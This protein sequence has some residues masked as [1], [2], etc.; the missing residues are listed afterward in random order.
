MERKFKLLMTILIVICIFC[1][2]CK[3]NSSVSKENVP[4]YT[5]QNKIDEFDELIYVDSEYRDYFWFNGKNPYIYSYDDWLEDEQTSCVNICF[6][7]NLKVHKE[8]NE[9]VIAILD[10]GVNVNCLDKDNIWT[11]IKEIPN[12]NIDDD[13][14]GYIDDINGYNFVDKNNCLNTSSSGYHGNYISSICIG[15]ND[16]LNY[17]GLLNETDVKVMFLKV[18]DGENSSGS[19]ANICHAIE[20]AEENGADICNLSFCY[21]RNDEKIKNII[22]KSSMTFI[23]AA[24][25]NGFEIESSDRVYPAM[26]NNENVICVGNMRSDG[27][28]SYTSNYSNNYVDIVAP[29]TDIIGMYDEEKLICKSG[30]SQA[31]IIFT[32]ELAF[33]MEL[34]GKKHISQSE[35]SSFVKVT[36]ELK[37]KCTLGGYV[38]FSYIK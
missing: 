7:D 8:S 4:S 2:V 25:N 13:N 34:L 21:N 14:N 35:L 30:T 33:I 28:F 16:E 11:N 18:L 9:I 32:C 38:D 20:Y 17:Y 5:E 3:E 1:V 19:I 29:G 36:R 15:R 22:N 31:S 27:K 10:D 6:Y 37:D 26:Y 23:V 24:G 12:N